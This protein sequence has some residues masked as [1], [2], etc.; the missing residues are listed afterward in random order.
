[1][2]DNKL[3]TINESFDIDD[4]LP[5]V[6]VDYTVDGG[7]NLGD[8]PVD[9]VFTDTVAI[10]E[11][12]KK[13]IAEWYPDAPIGQQITFSKQ[14]TKIPHWNFFPIK[15]LLNVFTKIC[16]D[17]KLKVYAREDRKRNYITIKKVE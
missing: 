3:F 15:T 1:M 16:K 11:A 7:I 6:K 8:L 13:D 5:K 17:Y 10:G 12:I 14:T 9:K 4:L 2:A